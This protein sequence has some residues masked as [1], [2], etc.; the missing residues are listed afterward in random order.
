MQYAQKCIA[1]D[2]SLSHAHAALGIIHLVLRQWDKAIEEGEIAVS[3]SPNSADNAVMLA[4]TYKTV[5]RVEEALSMLEKAMRLNPMPPNWYLHEFGTCYRLMGKYEE[6]IAM[7]KRVLN[8]SPE[9]LN[10]RLNL[11]ATYVMSGEEEAARIEAVEVL[12][13]SPDF[14][15]AR[16][17]K[18]FPYKDHQGRTEVKSRQYML[19]QAPE[20]NISYILQESQISLRYRYI[21]SKF[22]KSMR[23]L[24]IS[25]G[26][27]QPIAY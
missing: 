5:G 12:K 7:L 11:I 3:L 21:E 22:S 8:R 23:L 13:Q 17:L 26:Y 24:Q 6:A 10:S 1:L 20:G 18:N 14:S 15:L 25:N 9:F 27:M 2:E 19:Y 4:V 16:F